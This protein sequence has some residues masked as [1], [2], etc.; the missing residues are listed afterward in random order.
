[1]GALLT[2][3][4][5]IEVACLAASV[6][7]LW[8]DPRAIW[9]LQPWYL[10]AVVATEL[11]GTYL[12]R[13]ADEP[14]QW[15]YNLYLAIIPLFLGLVLYHIIY[16]LTPIRRVWLYG[17]WVAC[18][19]VY[20]AETW[21]TGGISVYNKYTRYFV[22]GGISIAC[23]Y[24]FVQ[25]NRVPGY[26]NVKASPGFWWLYGT[27][28]FYIGHWVITLFAPLLLHPGA[29]IFGIRLYKAL[30]FILIYSLYGLWSYAFYLRWRTRR[31]SPNS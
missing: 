8:R 23:I 22:N 16:A 27:C 31:P 11:T 3:Y 24:Y 14:N 2:Y 17:W 15:V 12:T 30:N 29:A 18:L 1:M 7:F 10:L 6:T 25:Q 5:V 4:L 20:V 26:R 21:A 9:R 28:C 19:A 13:I